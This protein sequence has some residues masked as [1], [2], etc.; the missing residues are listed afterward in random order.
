MNK[1]KPPPIPKKYLDLADKVYDR[2]SL[3]R[4]S[5]ALKLAL[6][7]DSEYKKQYDDYLKK[8]KTN[9]KPYSI[10]QWFKEKWVN[11]REYLKGNIVECGSDEPEKFPACRPLVRINKK[12]PIT[13]PELLDAG[14]SKSSILF[15]IQK[16]EKNPD[17]VIKWKNLL[18]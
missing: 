10:N 5:Y 4:S 17:Y 6:K 11:V 13:L 2:P 18:K 16:K 1:I 14:V 8:T 9:K 15:E 3:Y 12:T 7:N